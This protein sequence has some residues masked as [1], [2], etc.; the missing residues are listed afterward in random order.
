MVQ[1]RLLIPLDS[2]SRTTS[3]IPMDSWSR[4][5]SQSHWNV[6][7]PSGEVNFH[8]GVPDQSPNPTGLVFQTTIPI[9]LDCL[10]SSTS[11]KCILPRHKPSSAQFPP[12]GNPE[13]PFGPGEFHALVVA[14]LF[15]MFLLGILQP[16]VHV[17]LI[18]SH[19]SR[20]LLVL[21]LRH[22]FQSHL[23]FA[24]DGLNKN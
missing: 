18:P 22:D 13:F 2:W 11:S 9:S 12:A 6:P 23:Q 17:R 10:P 19:P 5:A 3:Q 21:L 20:T 14:F 7:H 1:S 16:G 4:P 8:L 24:L 15:G